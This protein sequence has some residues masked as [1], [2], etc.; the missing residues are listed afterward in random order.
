M[1]ASSKGCHIGYFITF[2]ILD[3]SFFVQESM[4]Q[5]HTPTNI[6]TSNNARFTAN[7]SPNLN[8]FLN[9]I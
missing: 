7:H 2:F 8:T 4:Y 1:F 6:T 3:N 9:I 5:I